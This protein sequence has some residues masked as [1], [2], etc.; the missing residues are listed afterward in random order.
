MRLDAALLQVGSWFLVL[1]PDQDWTKDQGLRTKDQGPNR[2]GRRQQVAVVLH[3]G[4]RVLHARDAVR[5]V[6]F[7]GRVR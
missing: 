1:G 6:E 4:L 7:R 5:P 3:A 2:L